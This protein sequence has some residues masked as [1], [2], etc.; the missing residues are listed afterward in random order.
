MQRINY[1][2]FANKEVDFKYIENLSRENIGI[3]C[4]EQYFKKSKKETD[5]NVHRWQMS[6]MVR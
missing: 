3:K 6:R 1:I 5:Y 4:F 2:E